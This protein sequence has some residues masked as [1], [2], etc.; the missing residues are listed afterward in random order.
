[1]E[2]G[3]RKMSQGWIDLQVNDYAG[4]D[5]NAR[6][7]TVAAACGL[8]AE[9]PREV[10]VTTG[11]PSDADVLYDGTSLDKWRNAVGV[12]PN[13]SAKVLMK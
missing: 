12:C 1:V 2:E 9:V 4:V 8:C 3:E 10:T 13:F 11:I 5:F 6:G 7:L